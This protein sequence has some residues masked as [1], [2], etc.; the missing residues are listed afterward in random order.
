MGAA[1][2]LRRN[3]C[4]I[5][6]WRWVVPRDLRHQLGAVEVTRSLGTPRRGDAEA[7]CLPLRFVALRIVSNARAGKAMTEKMSD[8][9]R[10]AKAKL[11]M[12]ER[13]DEADAL[14]DDA[15][16]RR[17]SAESRMRVQ[18][19]AHS[20]SLSMV[21]ASVLKTAHDADGPLLS[22]CS[23]S[24]CAERATQS[25]WTEKTAE[26]W[27]VTFRLLLEGLGDR[28]V[29]RV[30]REDIS[31]FMQRLRRLPANA[32]KNAALVGRPFLEVTRLTGY[33]T[34]A[35]GTVNDFMTRVSGFFKWA[36]Q[37]EEY[38]VKRNPAQG[39]AVKNAAR[40]ARQAFTVDQLVAL[41]SSDSFTTRR[42][43][44]PHRY[45]LMPLSL[46][47][48]MRLN[49]ACQLR[50]SDF[51]EVSGVPIIRCADLSHGR[52]RKNANA[53]RR[54]PV[55]DELVRLGL[56]RYVAALRAAGETQLFP[57]LKAGRDGHGQGPSKWFGA[58]RKRCGIVGRQTEVFHSFRHAFIGARMDRSIAP[59]KI[60]AVVGHE[61]GVITGDVYWQDRD[62]ASLLEV[63]NAAGLP[64]LVRPLVPLIEDVRFEKS[65]PMP[66]SRL[67]ARKSRATRIADAAA[68]RALKSV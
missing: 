10:A 1:G 68:R 17:I 38:G 12:M 41:F 9:L 18:A 4:G 42:F 25:A 47:T 13:L 39:F 54:I 58:Y 26:R 28:P 24:F 59:H 61:T 3:R 36:A 22:I 55:H 6:V 44:H 20:D 34:I 46:L 7:L 27:R 52:R 56:L 21:A 45:W 30:R 8:L 31:A 40:T 23:A 19:I 67:G 62:A 32:Q 49:E 5:W 60:A 16:S 64:D 14:V 35:D 51:A 43:L 15:H 48:G 37:V 50:V 66:P 63:V 57:E 65:S 11:Q 53:T 33:A 29:N 2:G